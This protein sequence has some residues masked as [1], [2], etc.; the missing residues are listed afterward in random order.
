MFSLVCLL[1]LLEAGYKPTDS[2]FFLCQSLFA[3]SLFVEAKSELQ[4]L[5]QD[6]PD[7]MEA[8]EFAHKFEEHVNKVR[9]I[10]NSFNKRQGDRGKQDQTSR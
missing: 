3:Q 9:H 2:R 4:K 7:N 10:H 1:G 8:L 5:L 6:D